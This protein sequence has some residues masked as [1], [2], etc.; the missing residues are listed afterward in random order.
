MYSIGVYN[1]PMRDVDE[2]Y[3]QTGQVCS[4]TDREC[5]KIKLRS[6]SIVKS[7][8]NRNLPQ[9]LVYNSYMCVNPGP[10]I[11]IK[12]NQMFNLARN[13]ISVTNF[14]YKFEMQFPLQIF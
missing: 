8:S 3:N 5:I 12:S 4:R 14:R 9:F 7:D 6:F 13:L 10:A 11:L 2:L 1:I